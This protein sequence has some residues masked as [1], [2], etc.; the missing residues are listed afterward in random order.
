MSFKKQR[1]NALC[2]DRVH[3]SACELASVADVCR[4]SMKFRAQMFDRVKVLLNLPSEISTL[5]RSVNE[6]VPTLHIY[7]SISVKLGIG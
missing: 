3:S 4:I 1:K 6:F 2:S 5:L 7:Y